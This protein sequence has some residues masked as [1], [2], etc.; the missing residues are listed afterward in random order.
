MQARSRIMFAPHSLPFFAPI[1]RSM[2]VHRRQSATHIDHVVRARGMRPL[3]ALAARASMAPLAP[4][5]RC[6]TLPSCARRQL[7]ALHSA[8]TYRLYAKQ[9]GPLTG[10]GRAVIVEQARCCGSVSTGLRMRM[11][12]ISMREKSHHV[13]PKSGAQNR[14]C[15]H[16][17]RHFKKKLN[18][19][20]CAGCGSVRISCTL[21]F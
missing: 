5:R 14:R 17:S 12:R 6:A 19:M 11:Q 4:Q 7:G 18:E 21:R 16:R 8:F 20:P 9:G 2:Q 1:G 13:D 3:R 10:S 15:T